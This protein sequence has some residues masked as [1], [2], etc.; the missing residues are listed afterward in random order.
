MSFFSDLPV[1]N[2]PWR[3][4]TTLLLKPVPT[5]NDK[6]TIQ[7]DRRRSS[8]YMYG[9]NRRMR[10]SGLRCLYRYE[11]GVKTSRN[12]LLNAPQ[13]RREKPGPKSDKNRYWRQNCSWQ[14]P[15]Y[16]LQRQWWKYNSRSACVY[17]YQIRNWMKIKYAK[18]PTYSDLR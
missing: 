13:S 17:K 11:G 18:Q 5:N 14:W 8:R 3:K 6:V 4:L 7:T 15:Y 9:K 12:S 2:L 1:R 16:M 10:F